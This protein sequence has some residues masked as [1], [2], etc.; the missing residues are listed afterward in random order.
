MGREDTDTE[1]SRPRWFIDLDWYPQSNRSFSATAQR[2]LCPK[3]RKQ[4]EAA[5]G[6]I[7]AADI[8]STIKDRFS[9]APEFI[10]HKLP[11]SKSIFRL[12]LS[13]GDQPIDVEELGQKLGEWR[14]GDT[15]QTSAEILS[16]LL[17]SDQYYGLRQAPG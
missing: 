14:A 6:E 9:K 17:G 12:L 13:H 4:P 15:C 1:G 7:T 8:L 2:C 5:K 16:R 10:T 11:I 3:C